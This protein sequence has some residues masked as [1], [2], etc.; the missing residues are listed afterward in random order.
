[1]LNN[2]VQQREIVRS[3][4]IAKF[5]CAN[6]VDMTIGVFYKIYEKQRESEM[7]WHLSEFT[8]CFSNNYF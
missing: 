7:G 3:G 1:M 4:A 5:K 2:S 8:D 6:I